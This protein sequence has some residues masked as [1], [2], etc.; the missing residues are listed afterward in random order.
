MLKNDDQL[1]IW[2]EYDKPEGRPRKENCFWAQAQATL[3]YIKV[4][5]DQ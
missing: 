5:I 3:G 4:S 2:Q 1:G